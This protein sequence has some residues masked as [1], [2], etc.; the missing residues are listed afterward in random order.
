M[1]GGTADD[2]LV[3]IRRIQARNGDIVIALPEDEATCK[4]FNITPDGVWPGA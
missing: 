3:I 2:D 4:T 1:I